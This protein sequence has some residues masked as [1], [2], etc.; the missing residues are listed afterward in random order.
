LVQ[1]AAV[2]YF[3]IP[4]IAAIVSKAQFASVPEP[5]GDLIDPLVRDGYLPPLSSTER[6][7]FE[8]RLSSI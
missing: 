8:M 2:P 4:F 7:I 6:R 1:G 3:A 5:V